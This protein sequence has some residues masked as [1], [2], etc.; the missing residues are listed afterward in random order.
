M[1]P[2]M[3]VTA[4]W[5]IRRHDRVW[6]RRDDLFGDTAFGVFQV[7]GIAK[8]YEIP[9]V[10][11]LGDLFEQKLQQ[12]D[13]L[14][15]MRS[16][17][18][19]FQEQGTEVLYVQGQHEKSSPPILQAI[20]AWPKHIHKQVVTIGGHSMYGLD[21]MPATNV[22]EELREMPQV[23]ILA[24][25]QVW[26]DFMGADIG[27][28][29]IGDCNARMVL[30][31]DYH[32]TEHKLFSDRETI[33]PGPLCMQSISE[34]AEKY[35]FI[36][37]EDLSA[38][39]VKLITRSK[40]DV[41]LRTEEQLED[42]IETWNKNPSRIPQSG[43]PNEI[44]RNLLRVEYSYGIPNARARIIARVG[45]S[46]HLFLKPIP[47]DIEE[48]DVDVNSRVDAV[49]GGGLEG[50]IREFYSKNEQAM[51]SAIRLLQAEKSKDELLQIYKELVTA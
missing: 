36:I 38:K 16:A 32:K 34:P 40:F 14:Q 5:H 3:L 11:L 39:K 41:C 46:V 42:F 4:D 49:I 12:S 24:T 1:K 50:C 37:Y 18:D 9:T 20:H 21:Y 26:R 51:L 19:K 17:L 6:V 25:H 33:S 48:I 28:A 45:N 23:D 30:T 29:W 44:M 43:V 10:L 2:L 35:V 8:K 31:G 13:A 15:L 7:C 22:E 47:A 27:D